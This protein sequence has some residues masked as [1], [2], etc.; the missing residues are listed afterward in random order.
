MFALRETARVRELILYGSYLRGARVRPG[1][2]AEEDSALETLILKG[3]GRDTPAIRQ[4]LTSTFFREDADP[5]AIQ[6]F[7]ELQR[8]SADADTAVRYH[9]SLNTRG[10]AT[11]MFRK[12]A[13]PTLV[14]HS[15]EDMAVSAD[16]GRL[17][18]SSIPGAQ[19]VLLP[20]YSHYF[21]TEND[22]ANRVAEAITRFSARQH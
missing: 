2:D 7:N 11:E 13:V 17:L 20:N 10:D 19:L 14:I 1:Y 12:V 16:E 15:Q 18:A 9:R 5:R 8:I 4:L 22:L 3:W 6:H 21:P